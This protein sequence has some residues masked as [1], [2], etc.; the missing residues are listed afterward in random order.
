L[1]VTLQPLLP[2]LGHATAHDVVDRAGI[3]VVA[4]EQGTQREA[5]QIGRVPGGER[6]LPLAD[7]RAHGVDDDGL[8]CLHGTPHWNQRNLTW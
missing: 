8:T 2:R 6:T 4:F 1:R 7:R 3:D 5:E